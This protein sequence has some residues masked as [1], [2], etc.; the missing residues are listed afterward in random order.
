MHVC[1]G[2]AKLEASDGPGAGGTGSR[3]QLLDL[4]WTL[5]E[6]YLIL[7]TDPPLQAIPSIFL[8]GTE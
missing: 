3:C 4:C 2:T 7:T 1:V 8:V 6:Q 5:S